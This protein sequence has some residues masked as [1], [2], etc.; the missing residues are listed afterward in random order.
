MQTASCLR[1]ALGLW[2]RNRVR[3]SGQHPY[4]SVHR[5]WRFWE[6]WCPVPHREKTG[7][8]HALAA[9]WVISLVLMLRWGAFWR[10][11]WVYCIL[12]ARTFKKGIRDP[13]SLH[14]RG[15]KPDGSQRRWAQ[16]CACCST[17]LSVFSALF[18]TPC[19]SLLRPLSWE[20]P[21]LNSL[22]T[23]GCLVSFWFCFQGLRLFRWCNLNIASSHFSGVCVFSKEATVQ[24]EAGGK[25]TNAPKLPPLPL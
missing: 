2:N 10:R 1:D 8:N 5:P 13:K 3:M 22:V 21:S 20:G 19:N 15:W 14:L 17:G 23:P 18:F 9:V 4:S 11:L 7:T 24:P 6:L 12:T 16:L 25:Y